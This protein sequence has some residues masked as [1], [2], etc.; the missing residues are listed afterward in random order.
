MSGLSPKDV[1]MNQVSSSSL[2]ACEETANRANSSG[3]RIA[4][5]V[6]VVTPLPTISQQKQPSTKPKAFVTKLLTTANSKAPARLQTSVGRPFTRLGTHPL[7]E[8]IPFPSIPL[9]NAPAACS[10]GV[11]SSRRAGADPMQLATPADG[12]GMEARESALEAS[13]LGFR[14]LRRPKP[15]IYELGAASFEVNRMMPRCKPDDD[16]IA[17]G[18]SSG[19]HRVCI[20]FAS[21]SLRMEPGR[22]E[23]EAG[24]D[25]LPVSSLASV[26]IR[27]LGPVVQRW[28]FRP[29]GAWIRVSEP[30]RRAQPFYPFG[31]RWSPFQVALRS[32][33]CV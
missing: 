31:D 15:L 14:K 32:Q 19:H 10:A 33:R 9:P 1:R 11:Q 7:G 21:G 26:R 8:T 28:A 13:G 16:P 27:R 23:R 17:I 5:A 25:E 12:K 29:S 2:G 4:P 20:G 22:A 24:S 3:L 18:S 6:Q 30:G